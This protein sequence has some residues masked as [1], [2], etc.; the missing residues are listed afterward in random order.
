M[1]KREENE[2]RK[3]RRFRTKLSTYKLHTVLPSL[4]LRQGG[5]ARVWLL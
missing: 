1:E 4:S 3:V 2:A 5:V